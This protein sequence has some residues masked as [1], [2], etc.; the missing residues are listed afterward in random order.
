ML[1]ATFGNVVEMMITVNTLRAT[2]RHGGHLWGLVQVA[3]GF[4]KTRPGRLVMLH[5]DSYDA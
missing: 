5:Y 4:C 1:N 3:V 2:R